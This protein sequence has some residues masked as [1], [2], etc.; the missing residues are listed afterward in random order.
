LVLRRR[1]GL[2]FTLLMSS[3]SSTA[4]VILVAAVTGV[5]LARSAVGA[6][7]PHST[8]EGKT[9]LAVAPSSAPATA[10]TP[11]AAASAR[12]DGEVDEPRAVPGDNPYEES[13]PSR[14]TL[15]RQAVIAQGGMLHLPGGSFVMGSSSGRAPANERPARVASVASFWLDRTEVTVGA[16]RVCVEAGACPRPAR[17]SASCTFDAGDP[18]LPVSC[19]HWSDAEAYCRNAGGRLPTEREWEYAARGGFATSFPWGSGTSCANAVTLLSDQSG[20]SCAAR[21]ARVGTHPSGASV[22]GLQDMSGNVEEWTG[23]WYV[24]ALGP[25]PA[26]RAG[27]AHVLRGGGW[28]SAPSQSRTT[29]RDWGSSLEAGPNAGFRCARDA[30]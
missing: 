16:Y 6:S 11:A 29:S 28:L 23:D 13:A 8:P 22:F 26:P 15:V 20:R 19:V 24:E 3:L 1:S 2:D 4:L 21:P 30:D 27:A 12:D 25:G 18:D 7:A 5:V 14:S 17:T 9:Q 10:S